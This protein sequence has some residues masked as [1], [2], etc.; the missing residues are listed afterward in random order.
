MRADSSV[1]IRH[2]SI[3]HTTLKITMTRRDVMLATPAALLA[4]APQQPP[5]TPQTPEEELTAVREQQRRLAAQF[6]KVKLPMST[7]PACHFKP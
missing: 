1:Y 3:A 5:P 4:Q 2:Q 7:E 6:D